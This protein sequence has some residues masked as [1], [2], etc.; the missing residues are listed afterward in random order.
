MRE[1]IKN[2]KQPKLDVYVVGEGITEQYYFT[3]LKK[4]YNLKYKIQ[5]RF[6]GNTSIRE[7]DE[8]VRQLVS[9]DMFVICV[10][11]LDTS[12][13]EKSEKERLYKFISCYKD[14]DNVIICTSL[15]SIEYWF[16]IHYK[17][18]NKYFNTSKEVEREL[19]KHIKNY[20]KTKKFLEKEKWVK[21]LCSNNKL[22]IA[23]A[24]AK[25]NTYKTGFY[26]NIYEAIEKV[27]L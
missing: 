4:L 22:Q 21:D 12:E 1:T 23:I 11:D 8:L 24:R 27:R 7:I 2:P 17:D 15:P 14:N 9:A 6:F 10:F 18:T 13:R 3:H 5:P 19:I 20:E 16:L 26:T 25:K